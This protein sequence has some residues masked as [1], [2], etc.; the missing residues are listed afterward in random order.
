MTRAAACQYAGKCPTPIKR[1]DR[2]E[3]QN[4]KAQIESRE[5]V[6]FVQGGNPRSQQIDQRS[7]Q[8]RSRLSSIRQRASRIQFHFRAYH[9]KAQRTHV[10]AQHFDNSP[11][12]CFVEDTGQDTLK[13]HTLSI[14]VDQR[15]HNKQ[16]AFRTAEFQFLNFLFQYNTMDSAVRRFVSVQNG[17]AAPWHFLYPP[18][19]R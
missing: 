3:I 7:R 4:S 6:P 15:R 12:T 17:D 5:Q 2:Q 1:I 19:Q 13:H 10:S 8:R 14:H 16:K 11:V 18:P 9:S